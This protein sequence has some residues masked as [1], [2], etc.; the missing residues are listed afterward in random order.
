MEQQDEFFEDGLPRISSHILIRDVG[1]GK[2]LVNQR[3]EQKLQQESTED[4]DD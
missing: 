3:G 4:D 2:V 1:T